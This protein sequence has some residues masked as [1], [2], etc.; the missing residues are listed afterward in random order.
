[1]AI[2]VKCPNPDCGQQHDLPDEFAG[3]TIKCRACLRP[4]QVPIPIKPAQAVPPALPLAEEL[5][6]AVN[7]AI[8]IDP[9]I[10]ATIAHYRIESL[11]GQG[12]MGKVYKARH[13]PL[14]RVCAIKV[15][16]AEFARQDESMIERF[17]RE[18]RS[19]AS[20]EHPN[21]LPVHFVGKVED[22]YF[23]EMQYVDGGS[24]QTLL[25]KRGRLEV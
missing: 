9:L 17:L 21:V 19:G 11:I 6:K 22:Q 25:G 8:P 20:V 7:K 14:E 4:L 3:K 10:G 16:P 15:L 13:I 5:R 18:A 1:M 24:L 23:I 12:A 2:S